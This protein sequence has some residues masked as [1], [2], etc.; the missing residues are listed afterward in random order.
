RRASRRRDE[1]IRVGICRVA[2]DRTDSPPQTRDAT[3][4][5]VACGLC[6]PFRM[7]PHA[8]VGMRSGFTLKPGRFTPIPSRLSHR[9][10]W[11][12]EID[13]PDRLAMYVSTN[14]AG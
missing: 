7:K 9:R 2:P 13:H 8:L 11:P 10:M 6:I 5:N 1:E 14:A 12:Q 4:T 3:W